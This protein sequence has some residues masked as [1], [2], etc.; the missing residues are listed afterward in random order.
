MVAHKPISVLVTRPL[1]RCSFRSLALTIVAG[2]FGVV[3]LYQF[4]G[5]DSSAANEDL[6]VTGQAIFAPLCAEEV[7][8]SDDFA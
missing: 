6:A 7:R 2:G 4:I 3:I 5:F 1:I 8:S